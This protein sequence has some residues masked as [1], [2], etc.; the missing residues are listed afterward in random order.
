MIRKLLLIVPIIALIVNGGC[1][2]ETYNMNKLS[3]KVHLS[4]AFAISAIKGDITLRD[5][6]KPNDTIVYGQDKSLKLVFRKESVINKNLSDFYDLNNMVFFSKSYTLGELSIAEFSR[7]MSFTLRQISL[8]FSTQVRNQFN[9]LHN[10]TNI[11][12]PFPSTN[13][14]ETRFS[15]LISNFESAT[16]ASGI[17]EISI[18]NNL[19]A[20]INGVTISLF[21]SSGHTAIGNPAIFS[22]IQ[23]VETKVASIDLTDKYVTNSILVSVYLAGSPGTSGPV[24]INLDAS[25]INIGILGKNL[26]V[27]SG[28]IIFPSQAIIP[29]GNKETIT[30]DPGTGVKLDKIKITSGNFTF[31]VQSSYSVSSS[32]AISLPTVTRG[33]VP[34][35]QTITLS[36]GNNSSG[37]VSFDST[38]IDLGKDPVQSYNR[39]PIEFTLNMSSNNAVVNFNKNDQVRLDITMQNPQF[40][41]VKGD[42]GKRTGIINPE[43]LDLG[44]ED[45]ISHI[46]GTFLISSPSIKVKY[47]NSFAIP[48]TIDLKAIGYRNTQT[49]SLGLKPVKLIYPSFPPKREASDSF[50]INKTNSRISQ[51][52]SLPPEKIQFSGSAIM[53]PSDSSSARNN[54]VFSSSGI[55]ASLEVEVPIEFRFNSI[56]FADT[57]DNFLKENSSGSDNPMKPENFDSLRINIWVDN[58][59]PMGVSLSMSLYNPLTRKILKSVDATDLL[60]PAQVSSS[61]I[62]TTSTQTTTSI[63]FT[64]EFFDAVDN[65][66]KIIIKFGLQTSDGTKDIKIFSDYKISYKAAVVLKPNIIFDL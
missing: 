62:V 50:T 39:L 58:G 18:T 61:G 59:F 1:V 48:V 63:K 26:K 49:D 20:S 7:T 51:L 38:L 66:D 31:K 24:P 13:L 60:K 33:K 6:A 35:S 10:T 34:L 43:T 41:Y 22:A 8:Q 55:L 16:F 15:P 29:A 44:I 45:I 9:A 27:K 5:I 42:F 11:F 21:N 19:K 30:F 52:I 12:P 23:P 65:A 36:P 17:L 56:Q 57:I 37:L 47:S 54:Y 40:D 28:R 4:P 25:G 64:K 3:G 32:L 53:N 14:V 46:T 2:K